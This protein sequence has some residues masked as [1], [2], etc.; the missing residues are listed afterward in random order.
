MWINYKKYVTKYRKKWIQYGKRKKK[1]KKKS[2]L[3][4]L[5]YIYVF[6]LTDV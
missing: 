5:Y 4:H 1:T 2:V 6:D 3:G